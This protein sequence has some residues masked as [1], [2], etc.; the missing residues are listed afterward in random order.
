M[1]EEP[2][3]DVSSRPPDRPP[4]P[5]KPPGSQTPT[6]RP[7]PRWLPL[8]VLGIVV[9]IFLF[10]SV[11]TSNTDKASLTYSQFT[12]AVAAGQIKSVDYDPSN[13]KLSGEFKN[14]QNGKTAFTSS[15]P[16]NDLQEAQLKNLA[17]AGV[18][19][20]YVREGSNPLVGILLWVLPLVLII[21]FFV[22]MNRRA[23]GQMGAVMN[24][25][26]SRAKVYDAEK[27]K[28]TFSDVA[29]YEPVKQEITE[30]VDFL[31]NPGKFKEI[32]ARIPRGVLLVGPPGTGKTL[33]ARAVAGEAGVPFVAITGSDF[34]EMFVGVGA[35]RVRDL[36][37]TARKQAPAIIFIDEID[38]IGRKRGAG[39]GGGHDEREQTLNQM[40]AE[41]DGFETSVGIV[42]IAATNRPDILDSALLRPGPVRPP[43]H[44]PA[45]HPGRAD[46]HPEGPLPRQEDLRRRGHRGRRS[47]YAGHVGCGPR[48]PRQRSRAVR[49]P[50]GRDLGAPRG[51]R[52]RA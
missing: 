26:R 20:K 9:A 7:W 30:V 41:M 5:G 23:Q 27:P 48:Q 3:S 38:S 52:G 13:G 1:N 12:D 18:D 16:N 50:A 47:R 32:G 43:D 19:V 24:I 14:A 4:G 31:K 8:V 35:A 29:G 49:G 42:M 21:G 37:Q 17:K 46:R 36:F 28:T 15:G 39:L 45:P 2:D 6:P 22:W 44:G 33:L 25:G 10:T 51:L 40:L 11:R 34:M